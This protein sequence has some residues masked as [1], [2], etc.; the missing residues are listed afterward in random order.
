MSK[1]ILTRDEEADEIIR[2]L[3]MPPKPRLFEA[4]WTMEAMSDFKTQHGLDLEKELAEILKIEIDREILE[5][6]KAMYGKGKT[7]AP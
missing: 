5:E 3:S 7:R 1:K 2:R 4:S 6:L